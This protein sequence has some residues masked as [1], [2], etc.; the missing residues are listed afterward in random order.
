M[1]AFIPACAKSDHIEIVSAYYSASDS[2]NVTEA[3]SENYC[4]GC[5]SKRTVDVTEGITAVCGGVI[6]TSLLNDR[7]EDVGILTTTSCGFMV[8]N[9]VLVEE[10][11]AYGQ[12]KRLHVTYS[13]VNGAG[14]RINGM[15]DRTE[16]FNEGSFMAINC[17]PDKDLRRDVRR[18][19]YQGKAATINKI[20]PWL[21][22]GLSAYNTFK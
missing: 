3:G 13:C 7:N 6:G 17:L 19:F 15:G 16:I 22:L 10:D 5:L 4:C 18:S 9:D 12:N 2:N 21:A 8:R 11:P 20:V 1:L 14:D